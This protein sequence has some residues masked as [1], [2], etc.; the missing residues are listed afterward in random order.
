MQELLKYPFLSAAKRV[1]EAGESKLGT[2]KFDKALARAVD[3]VRIGVAKRLSS[4]RYLAG[5]SPQEAAEVFTT[6]RLLLSLTESDYYSN[7]FA[8]GEAVSARKFLEKERNNEFGEVVGDFFPSFALAEK[9]EQTISEAEKNSQNFFELLLTDFLAWCDGLP[10][11]QLSKGKILVSREEALSLFEK[12][13]FF[14][15]RRRL[16]ASGELPP[17]FKEY[18]FELK[19]RLDSDSSLVQRAPRDYSGQYLSLPCIQWIL[20]GVAEGKRYYASMALAVACRKDN[21]PREQAAQAMQQFVDACGK[22]AHPFTIREGLASL[23]WVYR[24]NLRFSCRYHREHGL[25][26]E[27]TGFPCEEAMR[28]KFVSRGKK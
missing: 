26:P 21:L 10:Q 1:L 22:S 18:S 23:D 5:A 19:Q 9:N 12:A 25:G 3:S 15:L 16:P 28:G 8:R 11:R 2:E 14:K 24:R 4:E 27:G 13:V 20:K 17:L 6:A 7:C